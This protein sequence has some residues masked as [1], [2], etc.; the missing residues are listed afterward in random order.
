VKLPPSVFNLFLRG[1]TPEMDGAIVAG[2][3][4]EAR[5]RLLLATRGL[6]DIDVFKYDLTFGKV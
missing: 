6:P 2:R 1:G 4:W 5:E 3:V